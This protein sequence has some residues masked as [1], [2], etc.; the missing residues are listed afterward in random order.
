MMG[1]FFQDNDIVISETGTS[2]FGM[3]QTPL[4]KGAINVSQVRSPR[5]FLLSNSSLTD[6]RFS[7]GP[8]GVDWLHWWGNARRSSRR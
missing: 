1:N 3:I 2:S 7:T 8:L 6:H 4:P 5:P